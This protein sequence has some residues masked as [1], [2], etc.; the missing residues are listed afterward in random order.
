MAVSGGEADLY[1]RLQFTEGD[2]NQEVAEFLGQS[3]Y[4]S[5]YDDGDPSERYIPPQ[6]K[7]ILLFTKD[8]G[9]ATA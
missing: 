3:Y 6:G 2:V 4:E 5:N 7:M 9:H 8:R 1:A